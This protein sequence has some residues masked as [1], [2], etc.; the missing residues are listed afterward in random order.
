V[1]FFQ[2]NGRG[3]VYFVSIFFLNKRNCF[4]PYSLR[5][6]ILAIIVTL[7]ATYL[8]HEVYFIGFLIYMDMERSQD[9]YVTVRYPVDIFSFS[10]NSGGIKINVAGNKYIPIQELMVDP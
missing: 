7:R 6:T 4:L 3:G 8:S 1:L 2:K 9:C 5:I 10:E